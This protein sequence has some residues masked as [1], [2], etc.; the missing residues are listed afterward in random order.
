MT[1][2]QVNPC[3][4]TAEDWTMAQR[5]IDDVVTRLIKSPRRKYS[6]N[7]SLPSELLIMMILP[8]YLSQPSKDRGGIGERLQKEEAMDERMKFKKWTG[9][10]ARLE[11]LRANITARKTLTAVIAHARA[12][13]KIP[14]QA[15][16]S[17]AFL[18][19]K[20]KGFKGTKG[21]RI[22]HTCCPFWRCFLRGLVLKGSQFLPPRGHTVA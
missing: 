1:I 15:A 13:W 5:D 9:N 22:I 21:L 12:T 17:T 20:K 7:H 3:I 2:N 4:A 10:K 6:P 19:D 16:V 14:T 8:H 18:L 11:K